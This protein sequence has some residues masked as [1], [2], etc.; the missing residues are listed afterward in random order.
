MRNV[1]DQD[2]VVNTNALLLRAEHPDPFGIL[3]PHEVERDGARRW[4]VH[5]IHPYASR[6]RD[7]AGRP[8][9]P[10]ER[11]RTRSGI[12]EA[13]LPPG[14]AG[15]LDPQRYRLRIRWDD[16]GVSETFDPYAFPPVLTDFDLHLF[17][18]GTHQA[19]Y[20]KMGAHVREIAGVHGVHFSVWAPNARRVSIVGDFS[21]WDGRMYPLRASGAS[22]VWE[23]FIPGLD[24]GAAY[25]FEIRSNLGDLP[26]MKSD[27]YAFEAELR[28]KTASLV[29]SV[30]RLRNG[31]TPHGW[32]PARNAIGSAAPIFSL[33][34]AR[35]GSWRRIVEDHNRW[36]TY[37]EV[38]PST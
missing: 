16:G 22:G 4:V 10:R 23:M 6:D 18:E 37:R 28:P 26:F 20:E 32:T 31:G 14:T 17:T 7:F 3:G 9:N 25:K 29:R 12:F 11:V 35:C 34:S 30:D 21:R 8:G 5:V 19:L 27:P 24:E 38:G 1:P 2:S 15:P 13:V 36:L 33:R